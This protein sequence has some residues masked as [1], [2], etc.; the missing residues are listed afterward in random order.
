MTN[1][2]T[3]LGAGL[4]AAAT[5]ASRATH[6]TTLAQAQG[7][8]GSAADGELSQ[9]ACDLLPAAGALSDDNN[10]RAAVSRDFGNIVQGQPRAVLKPASATDV[11][12]LVRWAGKSGHKIAARGQGHSTYGR[13]L[14]EGGVVIEMTSLN[15]IHHIA[16]DRI[17]V[18]AGT[19]WERVLEATLAQGLTP[20]VL[21]NYLGLSVGGTISV[22]GIGGSSSRHGMQ[23]DHV[24][25]LDMVTGTGEQLT[26]SPQSHADLFDAARAGLAQ[27]GLITRATL[28]LVRAPERVRRYQLFYRDLAS[29]AADQRRALHDDRFEQLQGAI[30]PAGPGRWRY[31]LEGA[32]FY[33]KG[34]PPND[35]A[36]LGSLSYDRNTAVITDLAYHDDALAFAKLEALL[37]SKGLWSSP[38][39]WLFTFLPDGDAEH[40]ADEMIGRLSAEEIGPLG[41]VTFYPLNTRASGTPLVRW[42]DGN[43]AFCFNIVHMPAPAD[44]TGV[45]Q[46]LSKNRLFYEQIR[47]A[48]GVQYPVSA[49]P[50]APEDWERHFGSA[51]PKLRDAKRR[52]DPANLLTPGYNLF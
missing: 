45:G 22:G 4:C 7:C 15:A 11:A 24:L 43:I 20:P 5:L 42:P 36:V 46:T 27:C 3:L 2:R 6:A 21:T 31:Q 23:T 25:S 12:R 1:R 51:W 39:P 49:L 44:A 18:D 52:Y 41:R 13:A 35:G 29:L 28:K 34:S 30:L 26:C 37:R 32:V 33:D 9:F 40:L 38:H 8:D 16:G 14:I 48:G 50:M 47:G 19:T 10:D 17:V